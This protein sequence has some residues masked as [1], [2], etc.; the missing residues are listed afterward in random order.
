MLQLVECTLE[1]DTTLLDVE[2]KE[3]SRMLPGIEEPSS[4]QKPLKLQ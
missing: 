4:N 2:L 3:D 1:W